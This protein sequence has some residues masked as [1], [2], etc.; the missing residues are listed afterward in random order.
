VEQSPAKDEKIILEY[1]LEILDWLL[2][3]GSVL[4]NMAEIQSEYQRI[5]REERDQ[6]G[7][8]RL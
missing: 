3:E 4:R 7:T 6:R 5:E 8:E 1:Q 2:N